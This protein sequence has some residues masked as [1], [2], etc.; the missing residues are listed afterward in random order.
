MLVSSTRIEQ[1]ALTGSLY[2]N[3]LHKEDQGIYN[4]TAYNDVGIVSS[5]ASLTVL[6]WC[7]CVYCLIILNKQTNFRIKNACALDV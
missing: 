1:N 5:S 4:C 3:P 2:F 6:G 7:R